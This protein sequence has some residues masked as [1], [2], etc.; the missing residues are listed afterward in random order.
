MAE[1]IENVQV[2]I[3]HREAE[4]VGLQGVRPALEQ[5]AAWAMREALREESDKI[6]T[7][8]S[9]HGCTA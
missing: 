2:A 6:E 9:R 5:S 3:R 7:H 4:R 8:V 1:T